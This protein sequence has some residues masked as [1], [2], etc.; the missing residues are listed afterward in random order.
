[1]RDQQRRRGKWQGAECELVQVNDV[2]PEI[3]FD[4][5]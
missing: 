1:M 2:R 4:A 3:A 5:Q